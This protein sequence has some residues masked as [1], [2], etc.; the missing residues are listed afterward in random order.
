MQI[1]RSETIEQRARRLSSSYKV[2][3]PEGVGPFPTIIMF[4]GCGRADE[5]QMPYAHA[6]L[7]AGFASI[8]IDSFAPRKINRVE[9]ASSVCTGLQLWGRERAG[10]LAAAM[11]WAGTQEW[12]DKG[13][14]HALG[15]SHGGWTIMDALSLEDKIGEYAKIRGLSTTV[16]ETLKSAFLVYPWCGPG[17][18]SFMRGW[19]RRIPAHMIICGKDMVV[20]DVLPQATAKKLIENGE[21]LEV[22]FFENAT[23]SFDEPDSIH[24][25]QKHD[26]EL[27]A[28]AIQLFIDF[29]RKNSDN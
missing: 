20:G 6:A 10:D 3:K 13:N 21:N 15:W 1:L 16:F 7:V 2:I 18:F 26:A 27:T 14:I 9:A 4:H 17:S 23:H 8:I 19:K 12:A 22:S 5:P 28:K 29:V 25:A 24:P 11:H